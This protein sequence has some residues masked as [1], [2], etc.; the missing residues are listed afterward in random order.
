M[1]TDLDTTLTAAL[2]DA[3]TTTTVS[4]DALASIVR[5]ADHRGRPS[6]RRRRFVITGVTIAAVA[7][8]AGA[9]YAA[10]A[11][12]LNPDQ[13]K[14]VEESTCDIGSE[15]ARLV[16]STTD[17]GRTIEYWTVDGADSHADLLFE[18]GGAFGGGG[19]GTGSRAVAHPDLPWANYTL[20]A[21]PRDGT[22]LG[23]FTFFGQAPAGTVAVDIV[24][25]AGTTHVDVTS[26][27]GYFVVLAELPVP[28]S[29]PPPGP[30]P[31]I[32]DVFQRVDAYAADGTMLGTGGLS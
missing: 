31:P 6:R 14:L 20:T 9:T 29:S 30:P 11:D 25:S 32:E 24:T 8:G 1:N 26:P 3:A 15:N 18:H 7:A 12:R 23:H 16:A 17:L 19:C 2:R 13:A 10:V 22:G 21:D 4:D 28:K 5:R 27:E